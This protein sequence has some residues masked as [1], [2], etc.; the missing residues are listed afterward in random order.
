MAMQAASTQQ[1]TAEAH[2]KS[3]VTGE[4]TTFAMPLEA[5]LAQMWDEAYRKLEEARRDADTLQCAGAA[6]GQSLMADLNLTLRQARDQR[7]C[8]DAALNYEIKGASGGAG[9]G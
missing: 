4:R 6:E 8:G 7:V 3:L 2:V 5:T 1:N 9:S